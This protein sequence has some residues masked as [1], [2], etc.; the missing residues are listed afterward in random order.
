MTQAEI[1]A[2]LTELF[3]DIFMRDDLVLTPEMTA[4][5]VEG[6]DSMRMIE[7]IM[8]VEQQYDFK[9]QSRDLDTLQCVGDLVGAIERHAAR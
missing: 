2:G 4:R 9:M 6:W 5:D 8:A 1:Y 3:R 7:I